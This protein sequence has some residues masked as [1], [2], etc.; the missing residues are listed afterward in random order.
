MNQ[1]L[2]I[3]LEQKIALCSG[4]DAWHTKA[5]PEAG[6]PALCMSDGPHGL[7]KVGKEATMENIN[8]SLPATCFPT[9]V[10][11]ACS[12]DPELLE[13]I[14]RAIGEEAAAEGVGL[15]LGPGANIKRSP[16]CG[17][18]FEYFSEDPYLSGKLAAAFIR[19][20][21][22][23]GVGACLKHFACNSQEYKRFNS[24]SVLDERTLREIYLSAFETAVKEGKPAAV[25]CA[26]NKINGLH[27][28]DH[29]ELLTDILRHDW[30]FDGMV[31]TDWGAMNDRVLAFEA[32][33]DLN[34]PGGSGYQER[35][36]LQAVREG[37]L[38]PAAVSRSA[39]RV[40]ALAKR[41]QDVQEKRPSCDMAAHHALAR[42]AACEA[43]VLLK[44]RN[45]ILPL[46]EKYDLLFIGPMVR[47][48]RIQGAGS[49]HI[50]PQTQTQ[51][52][53]LR[54]DIPWVQ[55]CRPDGTRDGKLLIQAEKAA[56][57]AGIPVIFAGLPDNC[58]SEGFDRT[59]MAMPEGY[60]ELIET[61]AAVNPHTVVVLISG[62]PVELPW[63]DKVKALLYM[64][65]PGEAGAEAI[66]DLLFGAAC[67]GGKLAETWPK[68]LEDVVCAPYYG[69]DRKDA[70]YREGI[71]CGYRYYL[72]AGV[73]PQFPFGFGLSYSVFSYSGLK[74]SGDTVSVR[75]KNTGKREASETVQL[76]VTPPPGD[77]YRAPM[78][79][80][81]F[82]KVRLARGESRELRFTLDGRSFAVWQS[83]WILPSGDYGVHI[84]GSIDDLPLSATVRREGAEWKGTDCPAW[85]LH[86]V[87]TPSHID[88]ERL[89]GHPV[90]ELPLKKG[91]FSMDN[92]VE[93]M[94]GQSLLAGLVYRVM[95]Q[96]AA[97]AG[98]GRK[99]PEYRMALSS[100]ADA[101]LRSLKIFRSKPSVLT[102]FLLDLSNG[103]LGKAVSGLIK[104]R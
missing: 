28:S 17:R 9:A 69:G 23:T 94:R 77:A 91:A 104:K 67:P 90:T 20:V 49:S 30:G 89:V 65:L 40:A 47:D 74:I 61:V 21:Q 10:L 14:G 58:E 98:G 62:S 78:E 11:S 72:K 45:S 33:C 1:D 101:P 3:S 68:R 95:E 53:D 103:R 102:E 57:N 80:K 100:M 39:S 4:A 63:L 84:G 81:A 35:E 29:R 71:Y 73:E 83:G 12:W 55:G 32:G 36:A 54:P 13:E 85:Y 6:I 43:A 8:K 60:N 50:R 46:Q 92:T 59:S 88:F 48:L 38:D 15:L 24:D 2:N 75:V 31:V 56:K 51:I 70:H 64:G 37:R 41:A 52:C 26:Y 42:R 7:R 44:N 66:V 93:E 76:Y 16:L 25:M 99:T 87:G 22:S 97:N 79:L 86:P 82:Q 96:R 18:N 5:M 27:C 19:G 34:M